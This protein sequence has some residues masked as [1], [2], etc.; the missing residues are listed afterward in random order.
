MLLCAAPNNFA[1][2][3]TRFS[4]SADARGASS[5]R[6]NCDSKV[7]GTMNTQIR[8]PRF[9]PDTS[10]VRWL[11]SDRIRQAAFYDGLEC[12][13]VQCNPDKWELRINGT[14]VDFYATEGAAKTAAIYE[15]GRRAG[16]RNRRVVAA[17][18][19]LLGFAIGWLL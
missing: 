4:A 15:S 12:E 11:A 3:L 18:A 1:A 10:H 9:D 6:N 17:V 16:H 5:D 8:Y 7:N 2:A 13:I 19:V 14:R